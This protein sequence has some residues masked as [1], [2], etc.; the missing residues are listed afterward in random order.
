MS[1]IPGY[2]RCHP[3][4]HLKSCRSTHTAS[5]VYFQLPLK[6]NPSPPKN[7]EIT[8]LHYNPFSLHFQTKKDSHT[9]LTKIKLLMSFIFCLLS[10]VCGLRSFFTFSLC[11]FLPQKPHFQTFPQKYLKTSQLF[12]RIPKKSKLFHTF[13]K[14]SKPPFFT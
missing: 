4:P 14:K 5:S 12:Q 10:L 11:A 7:S 8:K 9:P 6:L 2:Q 1:R 3:Q 13:P